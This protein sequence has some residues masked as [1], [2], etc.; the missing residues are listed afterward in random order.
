MK[1]K[2]KH[3]YSF[4]TAVPIKSMISI[5]AGFAVCLAGF[6]LLL[7]PGAVRAQSSSAEGFCPLPIKYLVAMDGQIANNN[8]PTYCQ[9][10][11]KVGQV[12]YAIRVNGPLPTTLNAQFL[13]NEDTKHEFAFVAVS[14]SA[15]KEFPG[16]IKKNDPDLTTIAGDEAL[17]KWMPSTRVHHKL[18]D[19]ISP[20][21]Q[22]MNKHRKCYTFM[23]FKDPELDD[24]IRENVDN[25]TVEGFL[26]DE[27]IQ[28]SEAEG[29]ASVSNPL[30]NGWRLNDLAFAYHMDSPVL[31]GR[32]GNMCYGNGESLD[33]LGM[34]PFFFT[35]FVPSVP[36]YYAASSALSMKWDWP[37]EYSHY[38][39]YEHVMPGDSC[40]YCGLS[41]GAAISSTPPEFG[42]QLGKKEYW[43]KPKK[44]KSLGWNA[45]KFYSP[46]SEIQDA[47]VADARKGSP[48]CLDLNGIPAKLYGDK[49]NF[50]M[51]NEPVVIAYSTIR[52]TDTSNVAHAQIGLEKEDSNI[53]KAECGKKISETTGDKIMVI[54]IIDNAPHA[55]KLPVCEVGEKE[56]PQGGWSDNNFRVI[57][58]YE[59]PS[60]QFVSFQNGFLLSESGLQ[61]PLIEIAYSPMF[62][63]RKKTWN[64]LSDF[65]SKNDGSISNQS[66]AYSNG[67]YT[68]TIAIDP[69]FI[70]YE[71][72]IPISCLFADDKFRRED[73][74][75]FHYAK[76]SLG[77][78]FGNPPY[79]KNRT[80]DMTSF[81]YTDSNGSKV[82][83]SFKH[84][85]IYFTKGKGPLKYFVEARD[86]SGNGSGRKLEEKSLNCNETYF[87]EGDYL[88]GQ[89]K[90][91]P[92]AIKYITYSNSTSPLTA[93]DK[94]D[95]CLSSDY[96]LSEDYAISNRNI[97]GYV[98]DNIQTLWKTNSDILKCLNINI[99][100]SNEIID[101]FQAWGKVE[102][103]D[104]IKP[105]LGLK[106]I[107]SISQKIRIVTKIN[108]YMSLPFYNQLI[109]SAG[110]TIDT[111]NEH[112]YDFFIKAAK[113]PGP[114]FS[115]DEN[116]WEF[117]DI[118]SL[119]DNSPEAIIHKGRD[120]IGSSDQPNEELS[121]SL[122][123][124]GD[125]EDVELIISHQDLRNDPKRI[126][127]AQ[128]YANDNI[129][130]QRFIYSGTEVRTTDWYKGVTST[131]EPEFP[132]N[133]INK[134][135]TSLEIVDETYPD[136]KSNTVFNMNYKN[137]LF[138][139]Y[140]H[141][142]FKNPNVKWTGDSLDG[143]EPPKEISLSYAI[144]DQN[145]NSR[146]LKLYFYIAPVELN[147]QTIEKKEK[148]NL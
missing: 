117:K 44:I 90:F 37:Y 141:I 138:Y 64:S 45:N 69:A 78:M 121:N 100:P 57:F 115:N 124:Y 40:I 105:N 21:G 6:M 140:P 112:N 134:G 55:H 125:G 128:Y 139:K 53:L 129:D 20:A 19:D 48:L 137:G 81:Y 41:H 28:W 146:A 135:Y 133:M 87:K 46:N 93:G 144:K 130:G 97:E 5:L 11:N 9:M 22:P 122:D 30:F 147:I 25:L 72:K 42:G 88:Q 26:W 80:N 10:D 66:Y 38:W 24:A 107:N 1:I 17:L 51:P 61:K 86:G 108:D 95:P 99:G 111:I 103:E 15:Y 148:R 89:L 70:V 7:S 77:D 12:T 59:M 35:Y 68:D 31:Y 104:K 120:Y 73:I 136:Y 79:S 50:T 75:P 3:G 34:M 74:I 23:G 123:P 39:Q 119:T 13:I 94:I 71:K 132:D 82:N 54:R 126:N 8:S 4:K 63:W 2:N 110:N 102:I 62:V 36:L 127:L 47:S 65:L 18:D 91:N 101:K 85:P 56:D 96:C 33:K 76:T 143:N 116:L 43:T 67:Y 60:Y 58:W 98:K 114:P 32:Y 106:I 113:K 27:Q 16:N 49:V 83:D 118:K 29:M 145:N 14:A 142:S 109:S 52:V 84:Q 131:R 92:D